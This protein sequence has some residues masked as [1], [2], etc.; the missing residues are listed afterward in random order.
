VSDHKLRVPD[1]IAE[2]CATALR[3]YLGREPTDEEMGRGLAEMMR[4]ALSGVTPG[5]RA[6]AAWLRRVLGEESKGGS[7]AE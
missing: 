5:P 1:H 7:D 2:G 4:D 3:S 6:Y